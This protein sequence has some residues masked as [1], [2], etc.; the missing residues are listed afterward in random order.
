VHDP[1][2]NPPYSGPDVHF[3]QTFFVDDL[4]PY[5]D[6]W[7]LLSVPWQ[8]EYYVPPYV[9][10]GGDTLRIEVSFTYTA[11]P[12]FDGQFNAYVHAETNMPAGYFY[13][14][15]TEPDIDFSGQYSG[16]SADTCWEYVCLYPKPEPDT[17]RIEVTGQVSGS[18]I[19]YPVYEDMMGG[20]FEETVYA[21][22][23]LCGDVNV[24]AWVD[25]SDAVCLLNY[26]FKGGGP[27]LAF[28]MT[29]VNEDGLLDVAD[30]I[31]LLNYLFKDGPAPCE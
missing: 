15:P 9:F 26:L 4:W 23:F 1:W 21:V 7:G 28:E 20:V 31:Y 19:S 17:F 2:Y 29:D 16:F 3:N 6:R 8:I 11:P 18:S 22:H 27:P 5:S 25:L 30:A 10:A 24:D 12:P 13:Y 14:P